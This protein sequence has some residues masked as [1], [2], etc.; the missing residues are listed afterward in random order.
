MQMSPD[1][2]HCDSILSQ[3]QETWKQQNKDFSTTDWGKISEDKLM[4]LMKITFYRI[5]ILTWSK[6]A[7]IFSIR[8]KVAEKKKNKN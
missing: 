8:K 1:V 3:S 5:F 7:S 2:K 4:G 6:L